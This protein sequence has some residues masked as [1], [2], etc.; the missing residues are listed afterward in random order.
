MSRWDKGGQNT[1]IPKEDRKNPQPEIE[2]QSSIPGVS[3]TQTCSGVGLCSHHV[4]VGRV[5]TVPSRL[6]AFRFYFS[7]CLWSAAA[8]RLSR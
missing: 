3:T 1:S 2:M 5:C 6:K 4:M 7:L 8:K